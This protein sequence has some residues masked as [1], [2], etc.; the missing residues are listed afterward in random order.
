[1]RI[2]RRKS[3]VYLSTQ[4]TVELN[5]AIT[6]PAMLEIGGAPGTEFSANRQIL[7]ARYPGL[8]NPAQASRPPVAFSDLTVLD[9]LLEDDLR[10]DFIAECENLL[11]FDSVYDQ[12][13][14]NLD[15][16]AEEAQAGQSLSKES[17]AALI[18]STL[19]A[20]GRGSRLVR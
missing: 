18:D 16:I 4:M 20:G 2:F 19:E 14:A 9:I 17:L 15:Q 12:I 10:E 5:M 3:D 6:G 8:V 7:S 13:I 1:M 11:L